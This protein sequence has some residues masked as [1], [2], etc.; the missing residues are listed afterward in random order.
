MNSAPKNIE[1]E[2]A[3]LGA[4]IVDPTEADEVFE[5]L[6]PEDFYDRQN[7]AIYG[8]MLAMHREHKPLDLITL[9]TYLR[10]HSD[11]STLGDATYLASLLTA[12]LTARNAVFYAES[13]IDKSLKRKMI[14][15]SQETIRQCLEEA[16]DAESI[17]ANRIRDLK[18]I[19]ASRGKPQCAE[20]SD[21]LPECVEKIEKMRTNRG[22]ITGWETGIHRFDFLTNGFQGGDLIVLAA[23][24]AMGKTA[25]AMNIVRNGA[26]PKGKPPVFV[27]LEMTSDQLGMRLISSEA[28]IDSKDIRT[29]WVNDTD[30]PKIHRANSRLDRLN[31]KILDDPRQ[32]HESVCRQVRR[33]HRKTPIGLL[34]IDYLQLMKGPKADRKDLEIAAITRD[35]KILAKTLNIPVLLLS[36]L[37][38]QVEQR[39]D[40]RPNL[41]DLRESGAIEQDADQVIFLYRECI[42]KDDAI[43]TEADIY[44]AK[45]RNGPTGMV[46]LDFFGEYTLFTNPKECD[47]RLR[48]GQG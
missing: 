37:N 6:H 13:V 20:L 24:P 42:Y 28:K 45:N 26:R 12:E 22:Q 18:E 41:G 7:S 34:V 39:A 31:I 46:Y 1:S 14:A 32:T 25:L 9:A 21:V 2:R 16:D 48:D 30:W 35:L 47:R 40:K 29:G 23:R 19:E 15:R 4:L 33:I 10:E 36:Q 3:V 17:L 43:P 27:S 8:A 44:L 5:M 11:G 38:R